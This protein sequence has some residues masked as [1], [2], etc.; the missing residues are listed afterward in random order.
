MQPRNHRRKVELRGQPNSRAA[1]KLRHDIE[2]L[3]RLIRCLP[4]FMATIIE[5]LIIRVAAEES[6][7]G[8]C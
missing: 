3:L 5:R 4:R 2:A 1:R 6:E 8:S 7:T